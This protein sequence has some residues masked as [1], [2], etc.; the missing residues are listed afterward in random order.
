MPTHLTS[1]I[2]W[3]ELPLL[4]PL[5][6]IILGVFWG[7]QHVNTNLPL[8]VILSCSALLLL[9]AAFIKLRFRANY[10]FTIALL[11]WLF[12]FA[13]WRAQQFS[14]KQQHLYFEHIE[15][16]EQDSSYW[17]QLALETL[18][19]KERFVKAQ[20]HLLAIQIDS[21][22]FK[23]ATASFM[24]YLPADSNALKIQLGQQLL[25]YANASALAAPQNPDAF[26]YRAYLANK[27][28]YHQLFVQQDQWILAE[29]QWRIKAFALQCR[30][31][32]KALLAKHLQ[33]HTNEYAVASALIL[34]DKTAL[35]VTLKTAYANTG[36][37]HVLAVSG[38]HVGYVAW[39]L[40]LLFSFK[41]FQRGKT[42][43][44]ALFFKLLGVWLFALLTGLSPSVMRAATMFSFLLVAKVL[45]RNANIYNVLAASALCLLLFNPYL[46]FDVGFQLSYLAVLGIVYFHPRIYRLYYSP[47]KI[48]NAIWNLSAVAIAAQLFTFP[49]SL[50]YFHQFPV[51]FLLSGMVVV[52]LAPFILVFGVLLFVS[53]S[54]AG[55][56]TF[57]AIILKGIVWFSNA[58][59]FALNDLPFALI[60]GIWISTLVLFLLYVALLLVIVYLQ[61]FQ[62]KYLLLSI[63]CLLAVAVWNVNEKYNLSRQRSLIVYHCKK[64]SLI[65]AFDGFAYTSF[66]NL[67]NELLENRVAKS[68]RD[69]QAVSFKNNTTHWWQQT[70]FIGFYDYR[71][72]LVDDLF[73]ETMKEKEQMLEVDIVLLKQNTKVKLVELLTYIQSDYWIIDGSNS[74]FKAQQWMQEAQKLGLDLHWTKEKGAFKLD[75]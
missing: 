15:G 60:D 62:F 14:Q 4:R 41:I 50:Y 43:Y 8:S 63:L 51:Y 54:I 73:V 26:D 27:N 21:S 24:L 48:V 22:G 17:Y 56:S 12:V 45:N 6:A 55:I 11:L 59:V 13:Y 39:G 25:V 66:S 64:A 42:K 19:A 18:E 52:T 61:A 40:S 7:V 3:R 9:Y 35:D 68:H 30:S 28:I 23:P 16:F 49:L 69:K 32:L 65:D 29:K 72:L 74:F 1:K 75:F 5:L 33:A 47:Y 37:I 10:F 53:A 38:L 67:N 71:L 20:A 2:P 36:A 31:S 44:I 70:A 57:V 58:F 34:G 46:L